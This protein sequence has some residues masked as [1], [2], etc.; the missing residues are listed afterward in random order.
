VSPEFGSSTAWTTKAGRP[1]RVTE[2]TVEATFGIDH[3][4]RG[5]CTMESKTL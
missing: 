5:H 2:P 4:A 1:E 3:L